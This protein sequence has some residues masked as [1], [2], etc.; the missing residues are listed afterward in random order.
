MKQ[1]SYAADDRMIGISYLNAVNPTPSV[2]FAYDP[3]FVRLVSM[4]DGT[5]TTQYTYNPVG[6]LGAL[7]LQQESGPLPSSTIAYVYDALGR[8][9][10]KTVAGA[11]AETFQY[12]A[13]GRLINH[14][15]DL[16]AFTLS[17][18]GQTSQITGRQLANATLATTWSYLSN[19]GDRRLAGINNTGLATSQYS[20][21]AYTTTAENFISAITETSDSAA[22]YPSTGGQ[23]AS[24]NNVNA[25]T[26]LSGQAFTYDANG[27]LLS[28]GQR[29]YTWDA[30]NRLV[31]ITYPGQSGKATA[32]A[33]DGLSRRTAITSTPAGGGSAVT[34]SYIWCGSRLCQARN[35]SNAV[36][37]SD[38]AEG[39]FVPG[40][41]AQPYYYGADQIGSVRRVFIS[42]SNA[43][44]Y[45]Y[46]PYGNALQATAPLT[47]FGYAGMFYNA[48]SGLYLTQYRA[49]NPVIGRW[50]SRDPSGE[51]TDAAS[52]LYAYVGGN[53]MSLIDP[54]G[55]ACTPGGVKYG[56]K[57]ERQ[58]A[59]RGWTPA[60]IDEA[61][62][63]GDRIDAVNKATGGPATR[64]VNPTTQ[65]SVVI[66]NTTNEVIQV[67]GP[68]FEFGPESGDVPGAQLRPAPP[69]D[70]APGS[71]PAPANVV[72]ETPATPTVVP[73]TPME[74]PA[75]PEVPIIIP[76]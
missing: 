59:P 55:L 15:S 13:I 21:F 23:T 24:Y 75:I 40:S 63:S 11:G 18:L 47:D 38:Y 41:P 27:N 26:N 52:N 61:V 34:T 69:A 60:Q 19:T 2:S 57:I 3:Y 76:E 16:G 68:D 74:P 10:S 28:D 58:M 64:Y 43:P 4:T 49:Y 33:Y 32:F 56:R 46:D 50:L 9:T 20:N 73:E 39:E 67:G 31:G 45:R 51:S 5:G 54:L 22:V 66:D 1:F 53:P 35:A 44:A 71:S 8:L 62:R 30:D 65:Q 25:L 37:R 29:N 36:T 17:Y 14:A 42:T 6:A 48:D 12:D 72:P 70:A 7:K